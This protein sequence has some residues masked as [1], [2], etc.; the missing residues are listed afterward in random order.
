M[1]QPSIIVEDTALSY[2]MKLIPERHTLDVA[3]LPLGNNFTMDIQDAI[4]A[5]EFIQCNHIIGMHYDTFGY[6]VINHEEAIHQFNQSGKSLT[7]L[8]ISQE[9]EL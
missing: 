5:S 7:L 2:D 3:F 1:N 4:K 8:N 9:I 6:I